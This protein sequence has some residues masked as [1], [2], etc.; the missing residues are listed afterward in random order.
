MPYPYSWPQGPAW[1]LQAPHRSV[2]IGR[3]WHRQVA[4]SK[5]GEANKEIRN[6]M[7]PIVYTKRIGHLFEKVTDLENIKT[8]I[9]NASKRKTNRSSVQRV[10]ADIDGHALKIQRMC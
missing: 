1:K 5:V 9:K 8:A 4:R 7:E 10:L 2:K 6:T 3:K